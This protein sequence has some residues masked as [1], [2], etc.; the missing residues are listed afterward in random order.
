MAKLWRK[1]RD[2]KGKSRINEV[3]LTT[4]K[5]DKPSLIY[6]SG[7]FTQDK[8]P[9]YIRASLKNM[10]DMM[11]SCPGE[12][13][14]V[15]VYAWSH[16]GLKDVFNLTAYSIRPGSRACPA[17]RKLA[18]GVIMPLVA[19]DFKI[20]AKGKV[21]GT[22][23][24][25]E[26]AK[27]NLRNIT[28]FGYSAG[29]ITAQECFNASLKMMQDVGYKEKDAREALGEVVYIGVGVMSRPAREKNRFTSLFLE[30]TNDKIVR[31]KNRLW[32]PLRALFA[33]FAHKLKIE[34]TCDNAC[35]ISAAVAKKNWEFRIRNGETVKEKVKSL[36]PKWMLLKSYHEM[37]RYVT[38]DEEL[39]PFAKM[40]HYGLANAVARTGPIS[41]MQLLEP[42][43][44]ADEKT[45]AAYR[46]K[47]SK[48]YVKPKKPK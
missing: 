3:D 14:K 37:P 12:R 44:G 39:S 38:Q 26:E 36:L 6:L 29:S 5:I 28:F 42:P 41:P 13:P 48:A 8:T 43:P 17:V 30:A 9:Q 11:A 10:E 15:D 40:V 7:F 22:P 18:A 21:S 2:D 20:D 31:L 32:A 47:I 1:T 16:E 46:D 25:L 33:H 45:A 35:I 34:P 24:P 19:K 4:L 23:L 27:K